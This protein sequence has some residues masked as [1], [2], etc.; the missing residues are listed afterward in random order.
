MSI[1]TYAAFSFSKTFFLRAKSA[2]SRIFTCAASN[3]NFILFNSKSRALV[4]SAIFLF[5]SL[6][7]ASRSFSAIARSVSNSR[8][9]ASLRSPSLNTQYNKTK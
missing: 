8:I 5:I 4:I 3:F 7:V 6:I 9:L 2:I 1:H